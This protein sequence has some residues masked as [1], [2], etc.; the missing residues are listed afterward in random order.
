MVQ[1][2]HLYMTT[3]KTIALTRRTFDYTDLLHSIYYTLY[4]H[5]PVGVFFISAFSLEAHEGKKETILSTTEYLEVMQD[6]HTHHE[7]SANIC[8]WMND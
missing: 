8:W 7:C 1:L 3:G 4:L 2:S 5:L 6:L